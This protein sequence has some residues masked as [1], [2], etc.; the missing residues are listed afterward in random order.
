MRDEL[1]IKA[2]GGWTLTGKMGEPELEYSHG[3]DKINL[4]GYSS[5][6]HAFVVTGR[7][8]FQQISMT[9]TQAVLLARMIMESDG[10]EET[11]SRIIHMFGKATTVLEL[12]LENSHQSCECD[13]SEVELDDEEE[14]I[15]KLMEEMV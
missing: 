4:R 11:I 9:K 7:T 12:V 5:S 10:T 6:W 3:E 15:R 13:E 1:D 2:V 14:L 8:H